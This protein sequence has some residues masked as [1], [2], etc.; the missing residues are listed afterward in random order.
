MQILMS[1]AAFGRVAASL[2]ADL[3][4]VTIDAAG[5]LNRAGQAIDGGDVD[6]E[7][8]WVSLDLY[9]SGQLGDIFG[10]IQQGAK[11]RWIQ[12]FAAGLDNAVF[13]RIMAKGIRITKSSAQAPAIAEYVMCHALSLLNP[14]D[15]YR[16]AQDAHEWKFV[17]YK[18]IASTR[19]IL[20][21]FGAIGLEIARR[22]QPFGAHLT[23]VRRSPAPEPLAA[24]VRPTADLVGLAPEADV[25]VLACALNDQ[26]RGL[27]DERFFAAMKPGS[28]LINIGRGGLVDEAAL[29]AGLDRGQPGRAVL[30]VFAK[31]PLP[32]DSW[33]WDHPKVRVTGHCAGAGDGVLVR[34]DQLFLANLALYRA[35]R[36]LLNEAGRDEVGLPL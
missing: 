34:G 3:D 23:V 12:M 33:F 2:S 18:E 20:V 10:R 29:R 5:G 16:H 24:D 6:P 11:G 7:V 14:I 13:T 9:Q 15:A 30:D 4:V 26:T 27:A 8:Y 1:D 36:P 31:E 35:G 19:W 25:V 17:G 28:L 32:A 22:L 21:G